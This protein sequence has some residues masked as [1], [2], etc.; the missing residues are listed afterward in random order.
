MP[1]AGLIFPGART[2]DEPRSP[3]FAALARRPITAIEVMAAGSSGSTGAPSSGSF[4]SSTMAR[5]ATSRARARCSAQAITSVGTT[6]D[7]R[8]A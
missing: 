4:L 1:S 5:A 8:V 7:S 6:P 3:M 2:W